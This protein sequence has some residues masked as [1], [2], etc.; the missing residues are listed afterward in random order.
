MLDRL[1]EELFAEG[2][3]PA[4]IMHAGLAHEFESVNGTATLRIQV[5]FGERGEVGLKKVGLRADRLGRAA[6]AH[7]HPAVRARPPQPERGEAGGRLAR[8]ELRE[9]AGGP[10]LSPSTSASS[11]ARSAAGPRSCARARRPELRGQWQ[12]VQRE[13]LVTMRTM[14]DHYLERLDEDD[15]DGGPAVEEIPID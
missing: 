12:T 4:A 6:Q 7:D 10:W 3:G 15:A 9:T 1:A 14:I 13:A 5:P 11:C 2:P 8:G